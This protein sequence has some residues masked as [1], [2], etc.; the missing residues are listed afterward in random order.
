MAIEERGCIDGAEAA[1][2]DDVGLTDVGVSFLFEE[3]PFGSKKEDV[4]EGDDGVDG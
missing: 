1:V 4:E 2:I 3:A